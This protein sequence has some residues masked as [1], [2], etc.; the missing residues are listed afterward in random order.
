M[1][2]LLRQVP[3]I[4]GLF[5]KGCPK[6]K[7]GSSDCR[8]ISARAS[9]DDYHI[10]FISHVHHLIIKIFSRLLFRSSRAYIGAPILE[11]SVD[12]LNKRSISSNTGL[13]ATA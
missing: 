12:V 7:P 1:Q 11:V 10:I 9:S 4:L 5:N 13:A 3:P 2:P 6:S 8:G